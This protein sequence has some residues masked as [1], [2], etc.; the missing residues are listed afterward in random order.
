MK[1]FL[2][3][4]GPTTIAVALAFIAGGATVT[5]AQNLITSADIQNGQVKTA[6][7][8]K[9]AVKSPKIADGAGG[10]ADL[11]NGCSSR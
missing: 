5:T 1:D 10:E 7:L 3:R 11:G 9:G 2:R 6:D 8:G 4:R